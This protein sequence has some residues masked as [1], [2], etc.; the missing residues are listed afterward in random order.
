MPIKENPTKEVKCRCG[1]TTIVDV[2]P[3]IAYS[4]ITEFICDCGQAFHIRDYMN[5]CIT[6][7]TIPIKA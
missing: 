1:K 6:Y 7:W 5:G 3:A 4:K 2:K